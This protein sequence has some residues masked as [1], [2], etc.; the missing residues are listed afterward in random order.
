MHGSLLSRW[1][2]SRGSAKDLVELTLVEVGKHRNTAASVFAVNLDQ[3]GDKE[4]LLSVRLCL[5]VVGLAKGDDKPIV[6]R[7]PA[8]IRG[9]IGAGV[10]LDRGKVVEVP[11]LAYRKGS[12]HVLLSLVHADP[13]R[14]SDGD[15]DDTR[16]LG[17]RVPRFGRRGARGVR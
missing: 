9:D 10:G 4:L 16:L 11:S 17:L 5:P 6:S 8:A 3:A 15:D 1:R 14:F 7:P 12:I 13:A 2:S